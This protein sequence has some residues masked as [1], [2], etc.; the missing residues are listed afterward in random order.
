MKNSNINIMK[1]IIVMLL[2]SAFVSLTVSAKE[3]IEKVLVDKKYEVNKD[4][5]LQIEHQYGN[6]EC[7][8]WDEG[9]I[10]VKVVARVETSNR[11]KAEK[12]FNAIKIN[13]DGDRSG[14]SVESEFSGKLFDKGNNNLSIDFEIFLPAS[15]RLDLEHQFG[16]AYI[17]TIEGEAQVSNEYGNLEINELKSTSNSIEIG[18]GNASIG[19][20]NAGDIEV[21][22]SSVELGKSESLS[23]E[24]N[25]SN[26]SIGKV[27][28]LEIE[29]E[30]GQVEIG[31]VAVLS[32]SSKFSD[33]KVGELKASLVGETEYGSFS[34]KNIRADFTHIELENS[35]GSVSLYFEPEGA[36][37]IIAE[38]EFCTLNYPDE[39]ADFSK[40]IVS[41][42][43][44]SYYEGRIGE[45]STN[46]S[47][48]DL[49][50]E[51]GGV[52][53]YFR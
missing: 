43:A 13:L 10:S 12:I 34:V 16:N 4:A 38:M 8:N 20:I 50:S 1:K 31:K 33:F 6:V 21:D 2:L 35:F 29:N 24:A 23:I 45:G 18:F 26:L 47:K 9:S 25:Y 28:D 44:D 46:G 37:E 48:V 5:L 51:Y 42:S 17:E 30:G 11:E 3:K 15:V 22:Y 19:Y 36:F 27:G 52:S 40:R 53:I 41:S 7:K 39:V 32:M 49:V 14:V